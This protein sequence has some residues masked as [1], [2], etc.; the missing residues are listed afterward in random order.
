MNR[1]RALRKERGISQEGLASVL[2]VQRSVISKYES[3]TIPL[4]SDTINILVKYFGVTAD[5][6]L[7]FSNSRYISAIV[8]VPVLGRIPAGIPLEAIQ[9]IE[10]YEEIPA[11]W[12]AGGKEYF[13]LRLRGDS[14]EPEYRDGDVIIFRKSC[15]CNSGEHCA[16]IVNGEDGTFKKVI[17][18]MDGIV[19]Q[20]LNADYEPVFYSNDDILELPVVV[21]GVF[22]ELRR[23]R[24]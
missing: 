11:E 21:I 15:T 6:L 22:E 12:A 17:R 1:I 24:R 4:T 13:A 8:S 23:K 19:L 10:D 9:D 16:V 3:C 20:P 14:M 2:S 7:C 18:R 5:Y